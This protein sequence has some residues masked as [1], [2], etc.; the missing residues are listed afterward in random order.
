[1]SERMQS[2]LSRAVEDQLSE[3]RQLAGA[4]ADVR[5][6]LSRLGTQL[7]GLQ[8]GGGAAAS[9]PQLDQAV[10]GMTAE[11]R[12]AVRL[13]AERLDG[14]AQLVQQRGHDLA[15]QRAAIE[16][17]KGA[18]SEHAKA[19]GGM[20][21]GLSALPA[22]GDRIDTL[23]GS[24]GTLTERLRGLEELAASVAA[25]QQRAESVDG[26]L[27]ELRQAFTGVASRA[28]QLPA[29]DDLDAAIGPVGD[30]LEGLGNRLGRI[31]SSL[32]SLLERLDGL[33]TAQTEHAD[34]LSALHDR[35]DDVAAATT[36]PGPLAGDDAAA[37]RALAIEASLRAVRERVDELHRAQP[38]AVDL[39]ELRE[40]VDAL[41][42]G[43][44]G[45]G[46]LADRLQELGAPGPTTA[47]P[48]VQSL[49]AEAV[50]A[51]ERRLA[52][53]IDEAVLALA[54]ALLRRRS[55]RAAVRL[56]APAA[57]PPV[58]GGAAAG[59]R[60]EG[61][62]DELE[63]ELDEDD[64]DGEEL[65]EREEERD[66]DEDDLDEDDEDGGVVQAAISGSPPWQTPLP[67][68]PSPAEADEEPRKRKP[69]WR[70][71]G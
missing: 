9:T 15:E 66:D 68:Q 45:T 40:R 39:E 65:D 12:E 53:H 63:D 46:G 48:E 4:L 24:L 22:F 71:G 23:Q 10:A 26:G 35:F 1:M 16:E 28:A 11:L 31:E 59:D 18:V 32:P 49:V 19:L 54:E 17:L 47:Q 60:D 56:D 41:H 51:S 33:A 27:R 58:G 6:Q 61:D 14:V 43:V 7:E 38:T 69:W 5:A 42:E 62:D 21:G 67:P 37:D 57:A 44:L 36:A 13:L 52:D 2:L 30:A 55:G 29:R 20:T 3:Q 50:A 8:S 25:L 34:A 70:P 64:L